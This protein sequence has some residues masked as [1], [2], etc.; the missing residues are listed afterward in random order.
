MVYKKIDL[1]GTSTE[2]FEDAVEDALDR[3]EETL[4]NVSWAEVVD[5]RV[6]IEGREERQYQVEVEVAFGLE[7][8]D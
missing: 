4:D 5:Q 3:A 2:S 7:D 6:G 8:D 1:V